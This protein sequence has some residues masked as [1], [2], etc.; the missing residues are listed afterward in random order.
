M[1]QYHLLANLD[2]M[3]YVTPYAVGGFLKQFEHTFFDGDL[4]HAMYLLTMTSPARGGGDWPM[5]D[6]SGRW[7]GNRVVVLGDYT[8]DSDLP[9][10]PSAGT[11]Y[12]LIQ[13]NGT[14]ISYEVQK[15]LK[16]VTD[17]LSGFKEVAS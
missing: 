13:K 12:H 5:T 17:T 2:T 8:E 3:E 14:D 4:A 10:V 1:G 9:L 6:V 15:S 11:L 7:A 16:V